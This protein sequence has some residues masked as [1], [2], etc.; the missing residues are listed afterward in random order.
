LYAED[1][2]FESPLVPYLLGTE[3]GVLHGR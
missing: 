3:R 2:T 1:A